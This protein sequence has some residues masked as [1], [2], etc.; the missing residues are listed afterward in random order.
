[1][2]VRLVQ[3]SET[4]KTNNDGYG[5]HDELI[6]KDLINQH[7]IYAITGLQEAL[8]SLEDV[9]NIINETLSSLEQILSTHS[10]EESVYSKQGV[11]GIRYYYDILQYWDEEISD[12]ADITTKGNGE[13]DNGVIVS[14]DIT[15]SPTPNN[16]LVKYSN[17][18][19]VPKI[20]ANTATSDDIKEAKTEISEKINEQKKISEDRYQIVTD[21]I[22]ELSASTTKHN[23]HVFSGEC[24]DFISVADI[25]VLYSLEENVILNLEFMIKNNSETEPLALK[26]IENEIETMNVTL[27]NLEVQRYRLPNVPNTEIFVKGNYD[28]YLYVNYI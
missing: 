9:D 3:Y 5:D 6:N 25:S 27:T 21:K 11:H 17:G 13:G 23:T 8:N 12:W 20:P 10:K 16:A 26:I 14:K 28:L 22:M 7:P 18:Y 1:M 2:G 4:K 19:Y 15:I 24:T